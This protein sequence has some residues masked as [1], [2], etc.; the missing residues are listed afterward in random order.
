M[1]G[2]VVSIHLASA[3]GASM[4]ALT[5]AHLVPGRGIEGDRFYA[6]RDRDAA[7]DATTC[8]VTLVEQEA[9]EA[10]KRE[11]SRTDSGGTA[12][13]NIVTRGCSLQHLIS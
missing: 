8:D 6:S 10:L 4:T 7:S 9:L 11:E 5:P 12:R 3:A 1:E 13:R 2:C